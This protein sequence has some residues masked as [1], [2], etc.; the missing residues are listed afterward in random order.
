M[1]DQLRDLLTHATSKP[2]R[3]YISNIRELQRAVRQA[4]VR[5]KP[6]EYLEQLRAEGREAIQRTLRADQA[7]ERVRLEGELEKEKLRYE[8]KLDKNL[9]RVDTLARLAERHYSAMSDAELQALVL[10]PPTDPYVHDSLSAELL[11]RGFGAE[12][13]TLREQ[14]EKSMVHEPWKRS[15]VGAAIV[16]EMELANP[17]E[18]TGIML[19]YSGK[20]A[21]IDYTGVFELTEGAAREAE[22]E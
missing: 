15:E 21:A 18:G 11:A 10:K 13:A 14:A 12:H 7:A 1:T 8:A 22:S 19:D 5:G 9:E 3:Q 6:P 20:T 4:G 16:R 17:V 2:A